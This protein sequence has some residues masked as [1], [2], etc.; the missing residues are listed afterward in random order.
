MAPG[1]PFEK[2]VAKVLRDNLKL[3]MLFNPENNAL[4]VRILFR[5]EIIA[6]ET[7]DMDHYHPHNHYDQGNL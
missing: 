3:K 6:S 1:I 4:L 5:G 2:Q 7:V